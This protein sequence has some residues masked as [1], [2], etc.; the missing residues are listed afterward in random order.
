MKQFWHP[1]DLAQHWTL[2]GDEHALLANKTGATHL[3]FAVLLKAFQSDERFPEG[4]AL[5]AM[6][7]K[8]FRA[9]VDQKRFV[10]ERRSTER[11]GHERCVSTVS[12][13]Q[14]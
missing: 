5:H 13:I 11:D 4:S 14:V 12:V 1:D 3:A 8:R 10:R 7:A 9:T 6:L 2:S